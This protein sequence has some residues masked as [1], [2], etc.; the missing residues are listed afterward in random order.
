M[1]NKSVFLSNLHYFYAKTDGTYAFPNSAEGD[2]LKTAKK[3]IEALEYFRQDISKL[4]NKVVELEK[5]NASLR[6]YADKL[7]DGL[8]CL[9]K[10]IEVLR[11]ANLG[12]AKENARLNEIIHAKNARYSIEERIS[13]EILDGTYNPSS[14]DFDYETDFHS[15]LQEFVKENKKP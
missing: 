11:E 5:E 14:T 13:N 8:P 7:V 6:E 9:P 1:N 3:E 10:D 12:L 15:K 4:L 2:L